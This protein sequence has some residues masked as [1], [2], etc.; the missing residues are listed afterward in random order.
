MQFS[1]KVQKIIVNKSMVCHIYPSEP[2]THINDAAFSTDKLK[3]FKVCV[4]QR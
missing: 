4:K 1:K 3:S 2:N